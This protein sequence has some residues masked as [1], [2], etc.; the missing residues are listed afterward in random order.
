MTNRSTGIIILAAGSSSRLGRPKQNLIYRGQTLLQRAIET[1][2]STVCETILVV[3]GANAEAIIPT[4][5]NTK[6]NVI[7]NPDWTGGMATSIKSGI[8]EI[9]KINP[10]INA[11]ILMLCDQ[12]FVDTHLLNMLILS[13]TKSGIAACAYNSTIGPPALFNKIYFNE[14]INLM[15]NEGA[16][17]LLTKYADVLTVIPYEQGGNDIDTIEDFNRLS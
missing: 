8:I 15:G 1:A 12:P 14:L 11:V 13:Q 9:E 17:N 10:A 3:L 4:I 2:A 7:E 16:K 6:V 5:N